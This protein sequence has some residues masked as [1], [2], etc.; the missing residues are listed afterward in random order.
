M[1]ILK[2]PRLRSKFSRFMTQQRRSQ[3]GQDSARAKQGLNAVLGG[4]TY[5]TA[6]ASRVAPHQRIQQVLRNRSNEQGGLGR[7]AQPTAVRYAP[8]KRRT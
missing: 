6:N 1:S 3:P 8:P 2:D 4:S 7:P 5:R